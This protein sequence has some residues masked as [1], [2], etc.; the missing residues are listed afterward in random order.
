MACWAGQQPWLGC[1][2]PTQREPP[3]VTVLRDFLFC[4]RCTGWRVALVKG[5]SPCKVTS[6][7]SGLGLPVSITCWPMGP[8][9]SLP[10][11]CLHRPAK[12]VVWTRRE[13]GPDQAGLNARASGS[14]S[15]EQRKH[16]SCR[17]SSW[18]YSAMCPPHPMPARPCPATPGTACAIGL[19]SVHGETP[20]LAGQFKGCGRL[21][22]LA[23]IQ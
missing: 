16:I 13:P 4:A 3:W 1:R 23:H 10:R 5:S 9:L 11:P 12:P 17:T 8:C 19:V 21:G 14:V 7:T 20:C 2:L 6:G 18:C 22:C 15:T